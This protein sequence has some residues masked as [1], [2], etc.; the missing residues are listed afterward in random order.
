M[1][2]DG[3]N[4]TQLRAALRAFSLAPNKKLGQ[5]FLTDANI[6]DAIVKAA[7]PLESKTVLEIGPGA[8]R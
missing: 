2:Y 3:A 7:G 6:A 8:G 4:I 5:H 1:F